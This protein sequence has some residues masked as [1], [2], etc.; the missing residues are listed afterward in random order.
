MVCT[1]L[2]SKPEASLGFALLGTKYPSVPGETLTCLQEA[3]QAREPLAGT[4]PHCSQQ[5]LINVGCAAAKTT[6]RRITIYPALLED[7]L[8]WAPLKALKRSRKKVTLG[9]HLRQSVSK[10][11]RGRETTAMETGIRIG[12]L[13]RSMS[14]LRAITPVC[15]SGHRQHS[16]LIKYGATVSPRARHGCIYSPISL[17]LGTMDSLTAH[18]DDHSSTT[19]NGFYFHAR[20]QAQA[21]QWL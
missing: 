9:G 19:R 1:Y 10:P 12:N 7:H 18:L 11:K 4:T 20:I 15:R 2:I 21:T 16:F 5:L 8:G 6:G 13:S 14:S 17:L 3:P